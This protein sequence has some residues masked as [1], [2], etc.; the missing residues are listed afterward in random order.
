MGSVSNLVLV[1]RDDGMSKAWTPLAHR[2]RVGNVLPGMRQ[3]VGRIHEPTLKGQR[4][5]TPLEET[6]ARLMSGEPDLL[7]IAQAS[8]IAAKLNSQRTPIEK[9]IFAKTLIIRADQLFAEGHRLKAT[10]AECLDLVNAEIAK[11][12]KPIPSRAQ[13]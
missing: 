8:K 1:A 13:K 11:I 3:I 2:R 12:Q 4:P 9:L 7:E 5:M 6:G 10:F